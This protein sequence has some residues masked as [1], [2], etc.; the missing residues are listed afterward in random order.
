MRDQRANLE[1]YLSEKI[2]DLDRMNFISLTMDMCR[3]SGFQA[4]LGVGNDDIPGDI[5]AVQS[6]PMFQSFLINCYESELD[7]EL[8]KRDLQSFRD[9]GNSRLIFI[10]RERPTDKA[11]R[12]AKSNN[13]TVIIDPVDFIEELLQMPAPE[14]L[15]EYIDSNELESMFEDYT[16][17]VVEN[18][19]EADIG[20]GINCTPSIESSEGLTA[21]ILGVS[22][23]TD[24]TSILAPYVNNKNVSGTVI[25][26]E[27]INNKSTTID[28]T[29]KT[30]YILDN[31]LEPQQLNLL[32]SDT[33]TDEYWKVTGKDSD[34]VPETEPGSK[35]RWIDVVALPDG[36]RLDAAMIKSNSISGGSI[37][38]PI[39]EAQ[40]IS[41][42]DIPFH[43]G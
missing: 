14:L 30:K 32:I 7:S 20:T 36:G 33:N 21:A 9:S 26:W 29:W 5:L 22:Y 24:V 38:I 34:D 43:V 35:T 11:L 1:Q 15:S 19:Y 31:G 3:F 2:S 25:L 8:F 10:P 12:L 13:N 42:E 37:R 23:D 41:E 40:L 4:E 28:F 6:F 18:K 27:I 17:N 16:T 39:Y